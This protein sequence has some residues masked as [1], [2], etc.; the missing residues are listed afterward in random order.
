[1]TTVQTVPAPVAIAPAASPI[2]PVVAAYFAAFNQ[3][4]FETVSRL[5]A[6]DGAL[7]PPF[8]ALVI[9]PVA[10]AAYLHQEATGLRLEPQT[11]TAIALDNGC[12]QIEVTGRVYAP[13]FTV[14]V[15]WTFILSPTDEIFIVKINLLA[16]LKELLP[17]RHFANGNARSL[18]TAD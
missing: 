12:T 2:H 11:T 3:G 13:W 8:E 15:A 4:D 9:S 14:N 10:I 6:I 1:M 16:S 7:Q 18:G 5:F 17:L